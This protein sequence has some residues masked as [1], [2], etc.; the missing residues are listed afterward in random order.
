[1]TILFDPL[2]LSPC[3]EGDRVGSPGIAAVSAPTCSPSGSSVDPYPLPV[4]R[5]GGL[6]YGLPGAEEVHSPRLSSQV[7]KISPH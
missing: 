4:C 6:R 3:P 2:H 1:M 7:K 5:T